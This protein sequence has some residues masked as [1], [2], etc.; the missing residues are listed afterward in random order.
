M[1]TMKTLCTLAFAMKSFGVVSAHIFQSRVRWHYLHPL[2]PLHENFVIFLPCVWWIVLDK[3]IM[4][5]ID[6]HH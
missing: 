6:Y 2:L 3:F 1:M 5:C 4:L